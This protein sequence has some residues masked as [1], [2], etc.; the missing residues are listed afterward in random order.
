MSRIPSGQK[1]GGRIV[2]EEKIVAKEFYI[3]SRSVGFHDIKISHPYGH[4]CWYHLQAFFL[5]AHRPLEL[6]IRPA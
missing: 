1:K 6:L 2:I 5:T 4:C 3:L